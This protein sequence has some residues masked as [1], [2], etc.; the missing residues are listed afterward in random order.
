MK[1]LAVLLLVQSYYPTAGSHSTS[2]SPHSFFPDSG[3]CWACQCP[4]WIIARGSL[5]LQM[6]LGICL[7]EIHEGAVNTHL[8]IVN[9][10]QRSPPCANKSL[11]WLRSGKWAKDFSLLFQQL[12]WRKKLCPLGKRNLGFSPVPLGPTVSEVAVMFSLAL[13][14]SAFFLYFA[15]SSCITN[16]NNCSFPS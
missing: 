15:R 9:E 2:C 10:G 11:T 14:A 7:D 4:A 8:W 13:T 6:R 3:S 16:V 12:P 1:L 5:L